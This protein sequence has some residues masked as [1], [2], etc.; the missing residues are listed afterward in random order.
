MYWKNSNFQTVHFI[1][2]KCHTIDEAYRVALQQREERH[3]AIESSKRKSW[4]WYFLSEAE[5]EMSRA[6]FAVAVNE[7]DDLDRMIEKLRHHPARKG[8]G[9]PD[10][11]AHQACQREEWKRVLI[12]RAKTFILTMG[13]I[14]QDQLETMMA[15]PDF[16]TDIVPVIRASGQLLKNEQDDGL[17]HLRAPADVVKLLEGPDAV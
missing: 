3:L 11:T 4:R 7:R 13:T 9:L 16:T 6:A 15:H 14:P 1:L 17:E 8:K 2:G 10:H 5:K 12:Q